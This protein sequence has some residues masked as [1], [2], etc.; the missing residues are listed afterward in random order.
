MKI[1]SRA[2][3]ALAAATSAVALAA[4]PAAASTTWSSYGV[5]GVHAQGTISLSYGYITMS[6]YVRDTLCDGKE[7]YIFVALARDGKTISRER[8]VNTGGCNTSTN[9]TRKW[10]SPTGSVIWVQECIKGTLQLATCSQ[11]YKVYT[12]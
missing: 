8:I 3:V 10:Y 11:S 5:G 2:A 6:G 7:A 1:K 12:N 4:S 9:F